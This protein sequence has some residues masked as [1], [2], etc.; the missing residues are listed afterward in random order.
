MSG[1]PCPTSFSKTAYWTIYFTDGYVTNPAIQVTENGACLGPTN[2]VYQACYPGFDTPT[3][4]NKQAGVW[5]QV[6][7][8]PGHAGPGQPCLYT[9]PFILN[10]FFSHECSSCGGLAPEEPSPLSQYCCGE[11]ERQDCMSSGGEWNDST[12]SC[13]S[14]IVIDVAGNGFDL[15][16]AAQ[17]VMFNMNLDAGPQYY[18]WT[19]AKSDDAWLTLDRNNNGAID[20]GQELFGNF[21]P[22]PQPPVGE[23]RN[24]FIALAEY[25]KATNGGN[26]DGEIDSSDSIFASLRLWQDSNHNGVSES[27]ELHSLNSLGLQTLEL[28]Y[29]TSKK[30]DEFGNQFR[31]RAKVKDAQGNQVGRW[32]WDVFLLRAP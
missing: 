18:S 11:T 19:S 4:T 17:G 22:Q 31:Y 13:T 24:G 2:G 32:A 8:L 12:C 15:T 23:Q 5:N 6:T 27:S 30:T 25:D 3:W 14:P 28:E 26:G 16:N 9:G 1:G 21:A 10:H 29:K 7:H 20:N